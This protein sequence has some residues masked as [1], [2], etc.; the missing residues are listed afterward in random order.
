MRDLKHA[1]VDRIGDGPPARVWTPVDFLDLGSRATVDKVA[2]VMNAIGALERR[3][4][5]TR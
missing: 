4:N 2:D 5:A 3:I 1:V